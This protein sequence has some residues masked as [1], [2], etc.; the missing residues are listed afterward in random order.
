MQHAHLHFTH[1]DERDTTTECLYSDL[2]R[3]LVCWN[4]ESDHRGWA[5]T[6]ITFGEQR[7]TT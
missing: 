5:L 3:T 6:H 7:D 2:P 1:V 4:D